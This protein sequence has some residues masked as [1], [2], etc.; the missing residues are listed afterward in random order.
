LAALLILF[1]FLYQI[2]LGMQ[3]VKKKKKSCHARRVIAGNREQ[4]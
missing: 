1:V 3:N 2:L 4:L